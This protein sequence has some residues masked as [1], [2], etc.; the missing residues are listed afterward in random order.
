MGETIKIG[1][2]SDLHCTY[3]Q[4][5]D[6]Q[7]TILF[8]NTMRN[9]NRRNQ[10]QEL[11]NLFRLENITCDY[12]LCPGDITN[13]MDVQGI[14]SGF[15]Y[16][17][18]M[19]E[20]LTAKQ[21]IC[22][23]GNH[24][25]DFCREKTTLFSKASDTLK[26]LDSDYYPLA[27]KSLSKSLIDDG[28]CLYM[29]DEV[30]ILCVNSVA[31]FTDAKSAERVYIP[32]STLNQIEEELKK[33]PQSILV[34]IA[35]THHHPELYTDLNFRTYDN[36]DY[37]ENGDKLVELIEKY[38]FGMLVHGHK[39]KAR[40]TSLG[41]VALFCAGG[42]SAL[43]NLQIGDD[44]NTFHIIEISPTKPIRGIIR[45]WSYSQS[46]GW[47]KPSLQFPYKTGFGSTKSAIE[48]AKEIGLYYK[49]M[50][51]Q[52]KQCI[53]YSEVVKQFPDVAYLHHKEAKKL[54][55]ELMK[56]DCV[57]TQSEEQDY[58]LYQPR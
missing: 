53:L 32:D 57:Y 21:L 17:R 27:N 15:G 2:I 39:H 8:S 30:A 14:I 55:K 56:Y 37:I 23:P 6:S 54:Y 28:F 22:T 11:L 47:K 12:L 41:S 58:L 3:N 46:A 7:D 50:F 49:E 20:V 48:W 36:S 42:F 52:E 4:N 35:L 43:Q 25:V 1:V 38:Y 40:L 18:E 29:D 13:K 24:D 51:K 33:I 44:E 26:Q 31:C 34:R 19:Q 10:V 5:Y 9:G 16:L 45:T